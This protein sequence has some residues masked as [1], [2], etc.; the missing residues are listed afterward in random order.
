MKRKEMNKLLVAILVVLVSGAGLFGCKKE[1]DL[2]FS[3]RLHVAENELTC[4]QCHK[5]TDEG[6]ME[7]PSMDTCSECHDIDLD[8]PGED[9]LMCHTPESSRKDY[10]VE[11]DAPELPK[12]FEDVEF[13]HEVHDGIECDTCHEGIGEVQDLRGIKWP[14]MTT[15]QQ[16]H[17]GDDAPASC[18][19]CHERLRRDVPPES[20]HGDWA[21]HHG[22]ESRFE[23]SCE[24]CHGKDKKFCQ[25]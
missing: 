18:D 6:K 22:F 10:A 4:D 23:K 21:M 15:C 14:E 11:E 8:N 25:E 19:T 9:C 3:H 24:Y 1:G 20:H 17:N 12:S 13:S 2:K 16:C 5:A 7:D